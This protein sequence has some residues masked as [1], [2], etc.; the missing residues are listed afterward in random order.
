MLAT[1]T[2]AKL[3]FLQVGLSRQN[4]RERL[5]AGEQVKRWMFPFGG[6]RWKP[7]VSE[8]GYYVGIVRYIWL[9]P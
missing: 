3:N 1:Q 9:P 4:D 2:F 8:L 7:E 5:R 6:V